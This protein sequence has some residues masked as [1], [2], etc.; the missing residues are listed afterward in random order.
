MAKRITKT[1][2][3]TPQ[4]K[5]QARDTSQT[6]HFNAK[7]QLLRQLRSGSGQEDASRK[8]GFKFNQLGKWESGFKQLK[9]KEFVFLCN[10]LNRKIKPV[11]HDLGLLVQGQSLSG[12]VIVK[13]LLKKNG[14]TLAT[15]TCDRLG[16]KKAALSRLLSG[17]SE[18][19]LELVF[20]WLDLTPG[21]LPYFT[22]ALLDGYELPVFKSEIAELRLVDTL[23]AQNPKLLLLMCALHLRQNRDDSPL[24]L[25]S[26]AKSTG[27]SVDDCRRHLD[28][29]VEN[30]LVEVRD[31]KFVLKPLSS[32]PMLFASQ[33]S[34]L[35]FMRSLARFADPRTDPERGH[36]KNTTGNPNYFFASLHTLSEAQVQQIAE[37]L[38][39][40][41]GRIES[42]CADKQYAD[43]AVDLRIIHLNFFDLRDL[44]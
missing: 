12:K 38:T 25:S 23:L 17:A 9:W 32:T 14:L 31:G 28:L 30:K 21:Y 22:T 11:L 43:A 42:I 3:K 44:N 33:D 2:H 29:L 34:G 8:L 39:D 19:T 4:K 1:P 26:L 7:Q 15:G 24:F 20:R 6:R 13:N 16:I 5:R 36:F 40:A 41:A 35:K 37:V 18:P 10:N 27:L